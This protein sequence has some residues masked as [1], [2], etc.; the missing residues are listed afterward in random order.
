MGGPSAYTQISIRIPISDPTE[1]IQQGPA[2]TTGVSGPSTVPVPGAGPGPT[3]IGPAPPATRNHKRMSSLSTRPQS[4]H[5]AQLQ[6][7]VSQ[8]GQGQG[9]AQG[10]GQNGQGTTGGLVPGANRNVSGASAYSQASSV[11]SARSTLGPQVV[12]GDPSSTWEMWDTIRA[13]CGYHPRLSI[14]ESY[15]SLCRNELALLN[16]M[17]LAMGRPLS[18]PAVAVGSAICAETAALDLS[19]P[20]PP[21]AGALARWTAEPVKHIWLPATSFISNAKGY[22]VLSKACQAF[23]KGLVKVGRIH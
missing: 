6:N 14:C 2:T 16:T 3:P 17:A 11:M 21:S 23:L 10:Q 12:G 5:Q 19:N 9:Q 8:A 15:S 7:L 4:M 13:M 1:L 22:P 18:Q 20:L